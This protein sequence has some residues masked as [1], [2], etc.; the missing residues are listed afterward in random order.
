MQLFSCA[1]L[2]CVSCCALHCKEEQEVK[3]S[4][5]LPPQ[6]GFTLAKGH[7]DLGQHALFLLFRNK[8][9]LGVTD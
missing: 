8:W 6:F 4:C 7:S 3:M 1:N 2:V 9:G 5:Y